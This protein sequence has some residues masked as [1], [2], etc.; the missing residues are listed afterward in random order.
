MPGE[1][2]QTAWF[3]AL[4][5]FEQQETQRQVEFKRRHWPDLCDGV[6]SKM[7]DRTYPHILPVGHLDKAFYPTIAD[8][9]VKYCEKEDIALHSEVLNLRSSQACCFNVLFPLRGHPK[10][11]MAVLAP[12]LPGVTEVVSIDFEWTGPKELTEWLGE[13]K[14]GKR[15]Q[16]RTSIDAAITWCDDRRSLLTLV[17]W[18]Y[19]ERAFGSCGGFNSPRNSNKSS[20]TLA[21]AFGSGCYLRDAHG[22]RYWQL[23]EQAGIQPE[24]WKSRACP[25]IGPFYQLMRQYLVAAFCRQNGLADE[26]YVL[27]ATFRGNT[28]LRRVPGELL[29]G[30]QTVEDS[31][32]VGLAGVPPL[33]HCFV[34]D[35]VA[36]ARNRQDLNDEEWLD[37]LHERYGV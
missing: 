6:W 24:Q 7:P 3:S 18:K 5:A 13:P 21:G 16:N 32:N 17:E 14:G 26:A 15:G 10:L 20:C 33:R 19:T 31:W 22:R 28:S 36:A 30:Q 1:G 25:F 29:G 34:E 9:V 4:N 2:G 8:A 23:L 11:A 27:A 35:L 12:I 37:Y